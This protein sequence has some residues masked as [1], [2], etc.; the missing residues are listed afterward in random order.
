MSRVGII[1]SGHIGGT[2]ARLLVDR[3]HEVAIANSR[4]PQTLEGLVA[5]LGDRALAGT[6]EEV[7]ELGEIIVVS[8]P[9]GAYDELPADALAGKTVI[10]TGN[11][12]PGRDGQIP[13]LD[14]DETTSSELLAGRLADATVVK[15]F[16]T[17][18]SATL[19][20]QG[21]PDAPE[22]DRLV[23]FIAGDDAAAKRTVVELISELG[24]AAIDTGT[25]AAGGRRQ[26]P[27]GAV[28]GAEMKPAQARAALAGGG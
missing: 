12:Y 28:Y 23:L 15:A 26:Q 2:L 24:F 8:T 16:N 9:L 1:G 22:E 3:G 4:G 11:Y 18:Q 20:S 10:D 19:A 5:E 17:M 14:R 25:L 21:R 13:E 27:D 6:V 7:A